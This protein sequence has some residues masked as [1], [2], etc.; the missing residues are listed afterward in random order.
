MNKSI[1]YPNPTWDTRSPQRR[2]KSVI[3]EYLIYPLRKK[4]MKKEK[5]LCTVHREEQPIELNIEECI[6]WEILETYFAGAR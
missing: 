5:K 2:T 1:Y 6:E 4:K 3:L